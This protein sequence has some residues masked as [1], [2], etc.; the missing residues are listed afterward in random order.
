M[1]RNLYKPLAAWA[2]FV[3]CMLVAT[4]AYAASGGD[5]P[6]FDLARAVFLAITGRDYEAI[7][8]TSLALMTALLVK[9][10]SRISPWFDRGYGRALILIMS[11]YSTAFTAAAAAGA[12]IT[13]SFFGATTKV[14][15]LAAGGYGLAKALIIE[16]LRPYMETR[17]PSWL[18]TIF[19]GVSW[20]FDKIS[21]PPPAPPSDSIPGDIAAFRRATTSRERDA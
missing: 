3:L 11:G 10:G 5:D 13:W 1:L 14:V 21:P 8:I 16:P 7:G 2:A 12:P 19:H 9:F 18:R 4:T 15:I 6:L 17:A 20:I